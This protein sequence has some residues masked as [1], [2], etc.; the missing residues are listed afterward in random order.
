MW[1]CRQKEKTQKND[2]KKNYKNITNLW[3]INKNAI[4]FNLNKNKI[5]KKEEKHF[6]IFIHI[7][8]KEKNI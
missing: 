7:N 8:K 1:M 6:Y 5:K 4:F 2:F 3:N